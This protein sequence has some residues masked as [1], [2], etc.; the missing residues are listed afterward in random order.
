M[1]LAAIEKLFSERDVLLLMMLALLLLVAWLLRF[2]TERILVR[3]LGVVV[4]RTKWRWDDELLNC[5]A[6]H[7]ASQMIPPLFFQFGL[8]FI[9]NLPAA[10]AQILVNLTSAVAVLYGAMALSAV[11]TAM[12]NLYL[13][14]TAGATHSIK[15]YVQLGKIA[16]FVV[17]LVAIVSILFDKSPL[18][19]L[20]GLGAMSAVLLLVFKDTILSFVASL[21]LTSN[22]MLRVGDWIEMPQ[23][24]ADG[25]VVDIALH[26]VK[27]QNWDKTITTIPTWRLISESFKNWRGM[28]QAGGRRI[29]RSLR[30]DG[31]SV[32]FLSEEDCN[33]LEQLNLLNDY[34]RGK[35]EELGRSNAALGAGAAIEANRRRLTNLGTFRAYALA[36]LQHHPRIHQG[37]TLMV[38]AREPDAQGVPVEV[39]CFTATTDWVEYEGIQGDIFDHLLSILPEFGLLLYQQPSGADLR[40]VLEAFRSGR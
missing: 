34:L 19:L 15:G 17:A 14:S 31:Q 4:L 24:G 5:G 35:R 21:Q 28:Q 8:Q 30:L 12:Q 18:I 38:R 22:D 23:V 7:R 10:A 9:P 32:K 33:R 27:V 2:F 13:Q 36:Y 11:L 16:V 26:T 3:I 20:S 29:M 25:D 40:A 6:L 37:M 39:Y 1:D